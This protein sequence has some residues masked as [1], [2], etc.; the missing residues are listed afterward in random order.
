MDINILTVGSSL[1][2]GAFDF[3]SAKRNL[4]R[5]GSIIQCSFASQ[6]LKPLPPFKLNGIT[7][8]KQHLLNDDCSKNLIDK[9]NSHQFDYILID[10]IDERYD[11]YTSNTGR[12]CLLSSSQLRAMF[13][14]KN[15]EIIDAFSD[16][17]FNLWLKGWKSFLRNMI[18]TGNYHKLVINEVY[19]H[20]CKKE[21]NFLKKIYTEV[22]NHIPSTQFIHIK[23]GEF[24]LDDSHPW[25]PSRIHFENAYYDAIKERLYNLIEWKRRV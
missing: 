10:F 5:V 18:A 23:E 25:G 15:G 22:K 16:E 24:N 6:G 11:I 17:A 1:S 14:S 7:E 4:N 8:Q 13:K 21:N 3:S 9:I 12:G 2:K 19:W 20:R